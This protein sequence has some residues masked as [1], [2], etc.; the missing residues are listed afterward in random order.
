MSIRF[1]CPQCGKQLQVPESIAGQERKCPECKSPITIPVMSQ[2]SAP[3]PKPKPKKHPPATL[4]GMKSKATFSDDLIDMTAMVDIVFFL[5]IFFM[6]TSIAAVQSVI[7]LPQP[8]AQSANATSAAAEHESGFVDVII[9]GQDAIWV[10]DEEVYGEHNLRAKL[11]EI[12]REDPDLEGM[13][14]IGNP[15]GSHGTLVM[16]LDAGADSGMSRL[17]FT[18]KEHPDYP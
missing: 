14:V 16:V 3:L 8:Q 4:D 1:S 11:R 15:E 9:D 18:V 12:K 2:A 7:N 13:H 10:D 6:V 5:L 17:K